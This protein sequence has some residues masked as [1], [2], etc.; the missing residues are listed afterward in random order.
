MSGIWRKRL[1]L[2]SMSFEGQVASWATALMLLCVS[3]DRVFLGQ[4]VEITG[5]GNEVGSSASPPWMQPWEEWA[6]QH[7]WT[8]LSAFTALVCHGM[9]VWKPQNHMAILSAVDDVSL[10]P[11]LSYPNVGCFRVWWALRIW[12]CTSPRMSGICWMLLRRHSTEM[13]CWRPSGTSL[14][15]VRLAIPLILPVRRQRAE[16]LYEF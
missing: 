8:S 11:T 16:H 13:W 4:E 7:L 9:S 1:K 10:S 15:Q 12:W 5:E 6:V 14:I 3:H 2:L